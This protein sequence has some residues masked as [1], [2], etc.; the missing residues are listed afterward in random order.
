VILALAAGSMVRS[1]ALFCTG[2]LQSGKQQGG[3]GDGKSGKQQGGKGD[4]KSGKQ[5]G[6]GKGDGKSG[7]QQSGKG[8]AKSLSIREWQA[9]ELQGRH[10]ERHGDGET[11]MLADAPGFT[12]G[13]DQ[14]IPAARSGPENASLSSGS[15]G[16]PGLC[17]AASSLASSAT[18]S[19]LAMAK[20]SGQ[21]LPCQFCG[22]LVTP[23]PM[24]P[25]RPGF[26]KTLTC[27]F[28]M[29]ELHDLQ[30]SGMTPFAACTALRG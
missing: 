24:G 20:D 30:R 17:F 21:R 6:K 4:G 10:E 15:G 27:P 8:D 5:T 2:K 11:K 3:K 9:A 1:P 14:W 18:N 26:V 16:P 25:V 13:A 23:P 22:T 19:A 29:H 12:P 7:K 28:C